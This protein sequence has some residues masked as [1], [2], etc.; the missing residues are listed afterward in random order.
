MKRVGI[1]GLVLV[2]ALATFGVSN[3]MAKKVLVG[4]TAAGPLAPGAAVKGFSSNLIFETVAGN[5]ECEENEL[6]GTLSNNEAVKIKGSITEEFSKG[7][8]LGIPGACKTSATGPVMI[9]SSGL[10]WPVEFTTKGLG[11]TKGSKKI[12][13]TATFLAVEPPNHCTFEASTVKFTFNV[14]EEGK[15]QPVIEVV[16]KQKFKHNKKAPEQTTLCPSEGVLSGTF[17]LTAGPGL[18]ET[19]ESELKSV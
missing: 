3:A 6:L 18:A 9:E 19:V 16:T 17:S 10:P 2:V 5:L 14:G 11:K 7:D 4:R 13:F 8:Y 12:A 15:P 1:V